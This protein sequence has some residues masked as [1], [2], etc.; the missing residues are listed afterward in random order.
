M[1]KR[2]WDQVKN[3]LLGRIL[4]RLLSPFKFPGDLKKKKFYELTYF[5]KE[6]I[7]Y[8]KQVRKNRL[9]EKKIKNL[10]KE[11]ESFEFQPEISVVMPVYNVEQKWLEAA[12]ESVFQQVYQNWQLC[13][14]DD[15]SPSPHIKEVL[16]FFKNRDKRVKIKYLEANRGI[17]GASNEALSLATGPYVALLDHDDVLSRDSLFEIVKLLNTHPEA[18]LIYTDED[19]LSMG[20][21]QLRPV[22]KPDWNP[23]LF[24]TYNYI[25]HLLVCKRELVEQAGGFRLGFEGSQDYDL[26]LR[27]TELTENIFHIP[28]VLYHWRMIPGSAAFVVDAKSKAFERAKRALEEALQRRGIRAEVLDGETQGTFRIRK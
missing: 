27:L 21:L 24:L 3:T 11:I 14:A 8:Q 28:K 23:D 22:F 17:S 13:I 4:R 25:C 2:L 20:G 19:K 6:D 15:A 26:L 1:S 7:K 16:N 9:T 5:T 10:E 12:I 18:E